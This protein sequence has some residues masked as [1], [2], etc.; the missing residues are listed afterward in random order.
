[1]LAGAVLL[2]GVSGNIDSRSLSRS[3]SRV[4][5]A[6]LPDLN[7]SKAYDRPM[8]S[9]ESSVRSTQP[10]CISDDVVKSIEARPRSSAMLKKLYNLSLDEFIEMV[11]AQGG[12]CAICGTSEPGG[13]VG[14]GDWRV[15]H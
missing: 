11:I 5:E 14:R 9:R 13:I 15:D 8:A 7:E 4:R 12:R 6:E 3:G 1:M 10:P 2:S